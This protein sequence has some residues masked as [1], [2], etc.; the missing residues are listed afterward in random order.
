MFVQKQKR[1]SERERERNAMEKK[2]PVARRE[3]DKRRRQIQ[4]A[5]AVH[6]A[7]DSP[8][9]K[10]RK[11]EEMLDDEMALHTLMIY[12]VTRSH[13]FEGLRY[14]DRDESR[15]QQQGDGRPKRQT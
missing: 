4:A 14:I 5:R 15:E 7:R 1:E 9:M 3:R 12:Q 10:Q 2:K 13:L 6:A 8:E 11:T